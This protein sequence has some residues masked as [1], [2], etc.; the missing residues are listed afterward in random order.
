MLCGALLVG[1]TACAGGNGSTE[2]V[3]RPAA[4]SSSPAV[5]RQKLAKT[6]FVANAGLA[7]GATYQ[8]IVKPWK[9]GKFKKGAKGRKFALVKAG[10]A[11]AFTYNRLKAAQ[12]NAKGDPTLAK[13]VAPLT[14][15]IDKLKDLP[16]QLRKGD[17]VDSVSGSFD[18]IINGVKDAGKSAGAEVKDKVPSAKELAKGS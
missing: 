5:E 8:W 4:A 12:R 14:A 17:G 1:G 9:A 2:A 10:L 7:A 13:A 11:G 15:G 3:A 16:K 18:D 6:R